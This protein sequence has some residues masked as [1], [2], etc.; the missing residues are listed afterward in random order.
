MEIIKDMKSYIT[1]GYRNLSRRR[2]RSLLTV[3]GIVLAIGFTVGLLSIS[4]GVMRSIDEMFHSSGPDLFV[5]PKNVSKMPFG[6]QGT[7]TLDADMAEAVERVPGVAL[8]EPVYLAFSPEGGG[9]GFGHAMTMV[10]GIPDDR[11]FRMR[12]SAEVEQGR[13]I[14]DTDGPV[15]VLGGMVAE[16]VEKGLGGHL[17]LITGQ[18]LEII[19]I[20]RKDGEAYDMFAYAPLKSLQ[21]MFGGR[22]RVSYFLVKSAGDADMEEV[23][24][25]LAEAFPE[26]DIQSMNDIVQQ[27]KKMMGIARGIHFGV[28]CFALIIGVLF[29]ACTMI[30]SVAERVREFATLRVIGAPGRYVAK[31][32]IAESITLSA[33]G[34][35]FGCLFGYIL[36]KLIDWMIFH[37]FGETFFS[38]FVSPRIFLTGL[39][40]AVIIG[41][42]AGLFPAYMIMKRNLADSLRYE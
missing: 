24:A 27:A 2:S 40:I 6:F 36:S 1:L 39:V 9:A 4:E 41:A 15:V 21:K 7:A 29:V 10:S 20:L 35:A 12:P 13:W 30:M 33:I 26:Q 31:L 32:I 25:R 8:V 16:N 37:F 14:R 22:G 38:T 19:G 34:G 18:K 5:V 11:F 23:S 28:S 42:F 3:L 17:E